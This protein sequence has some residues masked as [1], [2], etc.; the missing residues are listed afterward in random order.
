M[1]RQLCRVIVQDSATCKKK[2]EGG[3]QSIFECRPDFKAVG[4][5]LAVRCTRECLVDVDWS[6]LHM[7]W[8]RARGRCPTRYLIKYIIGT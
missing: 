4:L 7:R 3:N 2:E 5:T 6:L 8:R 1:P